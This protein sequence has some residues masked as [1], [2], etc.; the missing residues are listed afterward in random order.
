MPIRKGVFQ[1]APIN[2]SNALLSMERSFGP[3]KPVRNTRRF[4]EQRDAK[5]NKEE[6]ALKLQADKSSEAHVEVLFLHK[7][8]EDGKCWRTVYQA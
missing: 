3:I 4:K 8:H 1:S 2:M 5:R 6:L 7:P